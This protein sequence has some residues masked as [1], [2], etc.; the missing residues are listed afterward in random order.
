MDGELDIRRSYA[1]TGSRHFQNYTQNLNR[2]RLVELYQSI[3]VKYRKK[4]ARA[5]L[6]VNPVTRRPYLAKI[7]VKS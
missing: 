1:V 4:D 6:V 7:A 3:S 2:V 5:S